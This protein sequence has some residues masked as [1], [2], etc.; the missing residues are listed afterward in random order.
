[1]VLRRQL[2]SKTPG[3]LWHSTILVFF[4]LN[5]IVNLNNL[6]VGKKDKIAGQPVCDVLLL[7][8]RDEAEL[9]GRIP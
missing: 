9:S 6:L 5:M 2:L 1:M 8:K 4:E 7:E 3:T